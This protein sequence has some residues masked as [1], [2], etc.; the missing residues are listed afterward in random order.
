MPF[1]QVIY[2]GTCQT[3]AMPLPSRENIQL[4][5]LKVL[6]DASGS[7]SAREATER[8]KRH[9]PKLTPEDLASRLDSGGNRL[10]NRIAWA[11]KDLVFTGEI[12][13]ATIGLWRIMDKGKQHLEKDWASWKPEYKQIPTDQSELEVRSVAIPT[14]TTPP[15]I[16]P[17][18]ALE[19]SR[20]GIVATTETELLQRLQSVD[21]SIFET[22][23]AQLL[24]KLEYGSLSDH[25][26]RVTGR[27]GDNGIDGECTTD[28]LGLF[29]V[30]F[31]AK[32]WQN[33]VSVHE[34][35]DF[36]GAVHTEGADHGIFVTTSEFT[37]EAIATARK[38]GKIKLVNGKE[39]ARIMTEVGLGVR[40][41]TVDIP[42]L[43]EEYFSGLA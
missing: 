26:I 5:L 14:A 24:E 27:S 8:V 25:T 33:A 15:T 18:E 39:L 41:K 42:R 13:G 9:Y 31:Q 17:E 43:D 28:R 38:S 37:Q 3:S 2:S 7:L 12:D 21:P 30:K 36:V 40:K 34:I 4:P 1:L 6:A 35:R 19:E 29:K 10:Y 20:R 16:D 23:V 11:R 22:I 32:R